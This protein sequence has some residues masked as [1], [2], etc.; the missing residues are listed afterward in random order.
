MKLLRRLAFLFVL[1]TTPA[2]AEDLGPAV[3]ATIPHDL[4][5]TTASGEATTFVDLAGEKGLALFFVRSVDWCPYCKVQA[6]DVNERV[7]DFRSRGY[8]VAFVSYDAPAKQRPFVKKWKFQPALISD[9]KIEIIEA[10]GLRNESH[11]EGSRFYGIPHPAVFIIN[12]DKSIA[13]KLYEED[14][15]VND[16]SYRDRPAVDL[17]LDAIDKAAQ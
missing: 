2:M 16:K 7:S 10:F 12:N 6:V 5:A 13:A 15:A 4:T 17:I 8:S 9:E 11:K 14:Y 1:L 3:G